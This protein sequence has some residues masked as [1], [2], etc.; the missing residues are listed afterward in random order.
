M[1]KTFNEWAAFIDELDAKT[2]NGSREEIYEK[3]GIWS[4]VHV[5]IY[6]ASYEKC[7]DKLVSKPES[8]FRIPLIATGYPEK[9]DSSPYSYHYLFDLRETGNINIFYASKSKGGNP[10]IYCCFFGSGGFHSEVNG[11]PIMTSFVDFGRYLQSEGVKAHL[12]AAGKFI[13]FWI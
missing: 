5:K 9:E 2:L 1:W 4:H 7:L 11:M 10:K 12:T 3:T 6:D 13:N 8:Y